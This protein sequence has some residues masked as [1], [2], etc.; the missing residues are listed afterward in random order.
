MDCP[1]IRVFLS[2]DVDAFVLK[3]KPIQDKALKLILGVICSKT[4]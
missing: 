3:V 4:K 1:G 2:G